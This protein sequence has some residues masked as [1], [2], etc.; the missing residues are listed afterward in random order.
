MIK[1]TMVELLCSF[2][3][4]R[5][6]WA[7]TEIFMSETSPVEMNTPIKVGTSFAVGGL[8]STK[9]ITL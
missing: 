3:N 9:G 7:D 2:P 4:E 5:Y 8:D 6:R 1:P